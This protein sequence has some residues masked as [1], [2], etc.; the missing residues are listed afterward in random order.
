VV[1]TETRVLLAGLRDMAA[2]CAGEARDLGRHLAA[3]DALYSLALVAVERGWVCPTVDVTTELE[4][5]AGRHAVL[6][7]AESFQPNDTHLVGQGEQDQLVVL[8]GPNMAGKSTWMRQVALIVVLA[9][10]GS[11]VPARTARIGMADAIFTRIG[12]VDDLARGRSTFMVEMLE[13]AVVL[14]GATDHSLVLLDEIGRGTSTHDGMAIAWAVIEHLAC[15]SARPRA[16][17]S[18]HYHELAVLGERYGHITLLQ[19]TVAEGPDELSFPHQIVLVRPT[20]ASAL[21]LR[22]WLACPTGWFAAPG[23]SQMRSSP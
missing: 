14:R 21:K 17:L 10:T 12:A 5:R 13:T 20:A 15:G 7:A 23:R 3:A 9:Q 2:G 16:I 19:A 22:V 1:T 18:T 11:F 8:T 4:I 6:E